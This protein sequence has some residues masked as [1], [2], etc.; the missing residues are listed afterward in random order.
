[1]LKK[2]ELSG[3]NQDILQL[4]V[5]TYINYGEPVGSKTLS[6]RLAGKL[7]PATIRNTMAELEDAGY[8]THPHTS[9]GRVPSEKAFRFYVD[10]L[11]ESTRVDKASERRIVQV[12]ED[13]DTPEE[14]MSRTSFL[15]SEI[16]KNIGIV[17]APPMATTQL[18]HIEFLDLSDGKILVIFVSTSGLVQRKVI[19]LKEHY[20]QADLDRAGRFLVERFSDRT[21]TEI[22]NELLRMLEAERTIYDRML[23]LLC[24]W[25]ESLEA[26]TEPESVYV[27]GTVNILDQAEFANLGA[28]R[29]LFRMLEEKGRLLK[30]LNECIA[31]NTSSSVKI[32]IGSEL[33]IPSMRDFTVVTSSY[34]A[35]DSTVGFLGIIGPVRMEYDR[36]ISTVG[37]L[38]RLV[39]QRINT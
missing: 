6:G 20:Q 8:L 3:R 1:M 4:L 14:L 24:S 31:S 35:K 16:S 23:K 28:V 21:L 29:E 38:G 34:V 33:G 39:S 2:D 5:Q 18:K 15:L 30:I 37:Y 19:R 11:P 12:L 25:N 26:E 32:A 22:R 17:I 9:A 36:V 13:S 10:L 7:S 27:Q